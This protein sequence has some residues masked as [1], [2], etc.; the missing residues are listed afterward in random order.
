MMARSDG[1][2][3]YDGVWR[4]A[5]PYMSARKN[6]IHI[7]LSYD[8]ADRLVHAYPEADADIVMLAILLHDIGWQSIDMADI[9]GKVFGRKAM[10]SDTVVL[11][12]KEGARLAR[13]ILEKESW[14]EPTIA[15]VCEIIDGHDTR[16]AAL[17][18]NDRLV[19]DADKLWR[20]TI[21][22]LAIVS[23]WFKQTPREY[24]AWLETVL[25]E[26]ETEA[27]KE[28][29]QRELAQTRAMLKIDLI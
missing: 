9:M 21:T 7:P 12:E 6:N 10:K 5:A 20:F 19:R 1:S 13:E 15:A 25:S 11:H 29:A 16:S 22:G 2:E 27:G 3:R 17:S 24:I 23:E 14:P 26:L 4:A 18:L 8:F 28:M